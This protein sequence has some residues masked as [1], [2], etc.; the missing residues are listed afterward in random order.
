M[1]PQDEAKRL[2]DTAGI[3]KR[4]KRD[5]T[6]RLEDLS[7]EEAVRALRYAQVRGLHTQWFVKR[8]CFLVMQSWLL[9]E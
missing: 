5:H 8:L 1:R 6:N 3:R 9:I 7:V 4:G 2:V